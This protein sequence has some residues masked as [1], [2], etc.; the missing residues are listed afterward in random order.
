MKHRKMMG[1]ATAASM[2]LMGLL[3]VSSASATVLCE[4]SVTQNC[5]AAW[6]WA[7]GHVLETSLVSGTSTK[8]RD[9]IF[10]TT[11]NTCTR[12]TMFTIFTN[13]SS[14]STPSG[15]TLNSFSGCT[16]SVTEA[17]DGTVEVH[18]IAGSDNGTV[19]AAGFAFTFEDPFGNLCAYGFNHATDIGNFVPSGGDDGV[20][21]INKTIELVPSHSEEG[22][23]SAAIWTATYTQTSA[24][25]LY[26]SSS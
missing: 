10:G 17:T 20:L 14:S 1:L 11:L 26:V 21:S 16:K 13:G 8:I 24:T 9:P 4:T 15:T 22:C 3:G 5:G 23:V 18:S 12:S 19:T 7:N 25:D 6:S 2:A